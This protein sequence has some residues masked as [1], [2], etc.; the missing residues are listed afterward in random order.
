[1]NRPA[2]RAAG[3]IALLWTASSLVAAE[4]PR[5]EHPRPDAVRAHWLNLNGTWDFRFDPKDEGLAGRWFEVGTGG[6]DRPIVVPFPWE[7]ELSGIR[8]L[9]GPKVGW[10]RRSFEVPAD[11]PNDHR[12]WL[13]FEAVD[14][15]ADVWVNGKK[16]AEHEGGYSPFEADV[17][18][19]LVPGKPAVVV[20][21]A[22]DPTDPELPTGKQVGWYTPTSGIW[23]TVWLESRPL[24]RIADWTVT[25]RL[26]PP[27]ATFSFHLSPVA[28]FEGYT[29]TVRPDDTA[30]SPSSANPRIA[31]DHDDG[32]VTLNFKEAKLWTPESP[33]LYDAT[34]EL[35]KGET[36]VDSVRT[37]FGLRTIAR[38]KYGDAPY[39]RILLNGK[40]IYLRAALD[41]SFNPKGIYTAP[42]DDF[43]K[44]DLMIAKF[45]GLNGLRIHIKPDEPRRLYWADKIG[46]LILEDMPN[47]WEQTPRAR[48]AWE[49]TM[50]EVIARDKNH[51]S[52]ITWV[53]FNE[54]WG[55][56]RPDRY[57]VDKD[58]QGW[59]KHMV[60]SIR[61][62]D[63]TRLV[64]DNSPCNYDHVEGSDLNSWHFYID[65]YDGAKSHIAD[66]V[67]RTQPGGTFNFCP[68]EKQSTAP[69]INSEYGGVSAGSGDRDVSWSFRDLTTQLR[70]QPKIQGYVYTE[71]TDIEW[72]HNGFFNYDRTPKVFAYDAF[73]PDMRVNE[74]NG[75]DFVGFDAPPAIVARPGET[76]T[77]PIFIS[78][79]SDRTFEPRLRW[80]ADGFDDK[81]DHIVLSSPQTIAASWKAYDVKVQAPIRIKLP[82]RAFV[83]SL[84]LTL[85]DPTD[86]RFAANYVNI[87]A[88]PEKPQPRAERDRDDRRD[89][90]LR[91][92]PVDFARQSW[93][94][95]A[96]APSGKAYGFGKGFFEYR[97]RVPEAVVKAR[98]E[99]LHFQFEASSKAERQKVDW[100]ER[101]NKQDYPQTDERKWP[102]EVEVSI[103]GK[104][105]HRE[106]LDDDTADAM[107][108]LAH[109][110]SVEH[111]SH[112][113]IVAVSLIADD[114]FRSSLEAGKPLVIRIGVP[115]STSRAG[116]LCIYGEETGRYPL[117]PTLSFHTRDPLPVDLGVPPD[118]P[119]AIDKMASKVAVLVAPGDSTRGK[120]A[121]WSFSLGEPPAGWDRQGFDDAGWSRGEA[122]FGTAETPGIRVR[123][124]WDSPRIALRTV[125]EAPRLSP[126]DVVRLHLFHDEDVE[127]RLNGKPI[128]R[129]EGFTTDYFDIVLDESG[130]ALIHEGPNTLA[131]TCRQSGGGQ[132]VDVGL[133]LLRSSD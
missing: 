22:F 96:S 12:T 112:G 7:S 100:P 88:R 51:P 83:G 125:F 116:G 35:R 44:R 72:E 111:G 92:S 119:V 97:I 80:W 38:G 76:I 58:T 120:P 29:V 73:I 62:L 93:S 53:A 66:V 115:D 47:T 114:A 89:A 60:A 110:A 59:V 28:S 61:G 126:G 2:T 9:K 45:N 63:S 77:V 43:L 40:P 107:G 17:T 131:V 132:G 95:P 85:R 129:A 87:I 39:E 46:L 26:D 64:E 70:R 27:S 31:R 105:V 117:E 69:L 123:T 10:Y 65:D 98:I 33:H 19:V 108:V 113:D 79:Y 49:A 109:V 5:P 68:G 122:G 52:I 124:R 25:T 1:M 74:L 24:V 34:I 103:N 86:G 50:R 102:S 78:H 15:R 57:K 106:G 90:L 133:L 13:R 55:L 30:V 91:F 42:D 75:A 41:Q 130:K 18:D 48:K 71:L 21:R 81:A 6:F 36:V 118:A 14:W 3:L 94:R 11:F 128:F 99:S 20:V 56:G 127:I 4:I 37:Y 84:N 67:A 32:A 82:D 23:Q 101:K 8:E 104:V 16:V 54:T 121:L